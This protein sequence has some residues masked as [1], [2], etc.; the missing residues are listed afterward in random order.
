MVCSGFLHRH[1]GELDS[2]APDAVNIHCC[3]ETAGD[4]RMLECEDDEERGEK[5]E[6]CQH[7]TK[8]MYRTL[9]VQRPMQDIARCLVTYLISPHDHGRDGWKLW[10]SHRHSNVAYML[11]TTPQRNFV[12]AFSRQLRDMSW[13]KT[14]RRLIGT[15][16]AQTDI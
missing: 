7:N 2:S 9:L 5:E 8:G 16:Q 12:L 1:S 4:S 14:S 6:I 11:D 15:V 3:Y 13:K 10:L